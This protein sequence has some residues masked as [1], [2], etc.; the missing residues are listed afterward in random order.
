LFV[1]GKRYWEVFPSKKSENKIREKIATYLDGHGHISAREIA[2]ELNK[3]IGGWLNYFDIK[4]TSYTA[5]SKRDLRY[6]L[7]EKLNR[8]FNRKSQ[9]GSR[10]YGRKAFEVLTHQYGMIDPTKY[11]TRT[12]PL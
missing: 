4:G 3:I 9:R 8:Y 6:Y 11:S 12:R 10:L 2:M 1:A 5:M 7:Y